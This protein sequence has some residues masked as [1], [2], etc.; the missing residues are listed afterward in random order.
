MFIIFLSYNKNNKFDFVEN[1]YAVHFAHCY[2]FSLVIQNYYKNCWEISK[3]IILS[4]KYQLDN[5]S[6]FRF[7]FDDNRSTPSGRNY[8]HKQNK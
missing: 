7:L 4:L 2:C 8:V 1:R 5:I 6:I 3:I